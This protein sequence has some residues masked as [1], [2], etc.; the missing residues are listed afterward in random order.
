MNKHNLSAQKNNQT[1]FKACAELGPFQLFCEA[2][3][4]FS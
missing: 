1:L 2:S 4:E 3:I